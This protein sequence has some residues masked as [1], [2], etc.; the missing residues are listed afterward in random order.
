[1]RT[2]M[3]KYVDINNIYVVPSGHDKYLIVILNN[4]VNS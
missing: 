3:N 2:L 4:K 1:M